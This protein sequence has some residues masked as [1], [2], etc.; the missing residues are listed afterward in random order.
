MHIIKIHLKL[1]EVGIAF[2]DLKQHNNYN[3][4]AD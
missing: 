4:E 2:L 1:N 3:K